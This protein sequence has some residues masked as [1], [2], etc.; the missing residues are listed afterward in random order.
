MDLGIK[1]SRTYDNLA[2]DMA[3]YVSDEGTYNGANFSKDSVR[4]SYDVVDETG[5]GYE[6]RNQVNLRAIYTIKGD[7]GSTAVGGSLE[8]GQLDSNG[9]QDDGDHY[10]A[11]GHAVCKY[12]NVTL[13]TQLTYYNYDV[14]PDQPLGTDRLVQMGAFDFPTLIAEEAWIPGVSLSYYLETPQVD[15]LEY[16]IPYVEYSNI[17]KETDGCNNSE[18]VDIGAAWGNGGWYIYTDLVFS[19][20]NDFVGNAVGYGDY[21]GDSVWSSNRVGENPT[22]KWE[23]R[24]NINFGYYF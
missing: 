4:Y 3:Y 2:I 6:E 24:F 10:A 13:A 22:D 16:V 12:A 1:Y 7:N 21:A 17:V 20:G 8:Y 14:E 11:S 15:W 23:Y 5:D 18:L 19:N 9:P